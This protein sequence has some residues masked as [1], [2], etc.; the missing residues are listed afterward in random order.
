ML[1]NGRRIAPGGVLRALSDPSMISAGASERLEVVLDGNSA[2]YGADAVAGVVNIITRRNFDGAE[3]R[4]RYGSGDGLDEK[5][6][7]QTFGRT[8]NTGSLF[9]AAEY[10]NRSDLPRI[11]RA[12]L[13]SDL[14]PY[15]GTDQRSTQSRVPNLVVSGV[16]LP[17][18][19]YTGASNR[20]DSLEGD[21]LPQ[22]KRLNGFWSI[23]QEI[24]A[25]LEAWYEGFVSRRRIITDNASLGG[26]FQVPTTNAFYSLSAGAPGPATRTIEYRLPRPGPRS[27]GKE[28]GRQNALGLQWSLPAEW[29][30]NTYYSRSTDRA[31]TGLGGEQLNNKTLPLVL[32]DS[33]PA[34]A[35]NVF[36]GPISQAVY[37]RFISFRHQKNDSITNHVEAKLDGPLFTLPGGKVRA[38]AGASY[39]RASLRYQEY[40]NA[41]SPTNTASTTNDKTTRREITSGY[42]EIFVPLVSGQNGMPG[43]RRLDLSLAARYDDYSDFGTTTNPKV[44]A[45]WDPVE[46]VSLRA[47]WGKSFRAPSLVDRGNLNFVFIANVADPANGNAQITQINITGSNPNLRPE[48]AETYSYGLDLRPTFLEGFSM[49]LTYY[50]VD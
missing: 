17:F 50:H 19:T 30:L 42:G 7:S 3:S 16:R 13:T 26:S 33:N 10:Y 35:L 5:S 34:T 22:Q 32:A 15:G 31:I 21:F 39:D 18:P 20:F 4:V 48:K 6:V 1:V 25:D 11:D 29:E 9:V 43:V 49:S 12:F 44:A 28:V 40:Q 36:G 23:R 45:V 24:N 14:R 2:I 41:L 37:D 46:G 47:T 8:W 38:A 27:E